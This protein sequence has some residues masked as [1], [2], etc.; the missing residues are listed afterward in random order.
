MF[1]KIIGR[2]IVSDEGF[3]SPFRV[4]IVL[5]GLLWSPLPAHTVPNKPL[6]VRWGPLLQD[7]TL[8]Q[9]T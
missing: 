8:S 3:S 5:A 2:F 4:S 7:S 6:P 9:G 1:S